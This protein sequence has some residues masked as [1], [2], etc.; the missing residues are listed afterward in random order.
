MKKNFLQFLILSSMVFLL[1]ASAG[2]VIQ[3]SVGVGNLLRRVGIPYPTSEEDAAILPISEIPTAQ[4]GKLSLFILAGQSNMVGWAPLP[5]DPEVDERIYVFGNDYQW[6]IAKE[7]VDSSYNQV[8]QVSLDRAALFG[9]SL[10]FG[11]ASLDRHPQMIIGLIPCA[12]SSSAILQWQRDLSDQSLYGSCLKRALAASTMGQIS[13]ILFFQGE[14]DALDP[15]QYPD[16]EPRPTDWEALFSA[17]VNDIRSDLEQPNLPVVF[18]QI[19]S[20]GS[21]EAFTNWEIVKEQQSSVQL[22]MT[23]M[24]LTDDLLLQ[25]GVHYTAESYR[26]IGERFAEAY[27]KLAQSQNN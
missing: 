15:I 14:A 26:A 20:T 25:D 23:S 10:A 16:P 27:W 3:K 19:G 5:D 18:A 12:K 6:R 2:A 21:P 7:P 13:G 22:T 9:P 11:L 4:R 8:D 1:G 17:F 24:I